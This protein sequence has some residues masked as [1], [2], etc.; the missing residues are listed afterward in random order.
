[1]N[2][3]FKKN[4]IITGNLG[5][6]KTEVAINLSFFLMSQGKKISLVDLDIINPYFRTRLVK[7]ELQYL[8]LHV[9]SPEGRLLFADLPAMSPAIKGVIENDGLNGVFDVGGDDVGATALGQ[10]VDVLKG[11]EFEM[12]F[13]INPCRPFTNEHDGII[14]HLDGIQRSS[15]IKAGRLV[16]NTNLGGETDLEILVKGYELVLQVSRTL[17]LPLAFNAVRKDMVI[18]AGKALGRGVNILPLDLFM[19]PPWSHNSFLDSN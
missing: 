11:T 3:K 14:K 12:L 8:G 1:M 4:T 6:G 9:V 7:N 16:N 2:T 13:V 19:T 5:S 17:G 15:G 10:Y 18:A